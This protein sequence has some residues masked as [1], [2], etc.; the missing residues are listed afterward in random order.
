MKL[1]KKDWTPEESDEWTVHDFVASLFSALSYFLVTI[2]IAGSL[3]LQTWGYITLA[4][5][6]AFAFLMY[7]VI[8]PKLRTMSKAYE[9]KQHGYLEK[10][11]KK[12]RWEVDDG[13]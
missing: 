1:F 7:R 2:G 8:D 4:A 13:D 11:E 6:L 9:E 3:L 5:S 12:V 10:L